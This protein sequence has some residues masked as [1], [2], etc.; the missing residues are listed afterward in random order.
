MSTTALSLSLLLAASAAAEP[1]VA[2]PAVALRPRLIILPIAPEV[3]VDESVTKLLD[4][5]LSVSLSRFVELDAI[6]TSDVAELMAHEANKQALGCD[7]ASCMAELAGAIGAR[8]VVSGR[9]GKLGARYS[10]TV[11]LFDS[12]RAI[13]IGRAN[14]TGRSLDEIADGVDAQVE[15][16]VTSLGL[17]IKSGIGPSRRPAALPPPDPPADSV[18]LSGIALTGG[19]CA[20]G[21]C[22]GLVGVLADYAVTS[23]F[24]AGLGGAPSYNGRFDSSDFLGTSVCCCGVSLCAIGL[25]TIPFTWMPDDDEGKDP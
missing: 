11:S 17:T 21:S 19:L 22:L 13:S 23:I 1:P 25:A 12:E 24:A 16:L 14:R 3:G 9:I 18:R 6:S 7:D 8:Y 4:D 2:A 15:E 10:F 20:T 5:L